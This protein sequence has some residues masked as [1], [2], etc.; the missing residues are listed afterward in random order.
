[1]H[2]AD[3]APGRTDVTIDFEG[4]HA[5]LKTDQSRLSIDK[6]GKLHTFE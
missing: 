2:D 4:A 3:L 1:M 5:A 6:V